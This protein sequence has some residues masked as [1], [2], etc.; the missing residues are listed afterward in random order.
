VSATLPTLFPYTT[1]FRSLALLQVYVLPR[2][3]EKL[4]GPQAGV[5]T[6]DV[7]FFETFALN[8]FEEGGL[9]L[10]CHVAGFF[11]FVLG[12][13]YLVDRVFAD[14]ALPHG[15]IQSHRQHPG[16]VRL[17]RAGEGG[18]PVFARLRFQQLKERID[19]PIVQL[20]EF[21]VSE[22]GQDMV[23]DM[24]LVLVQRIELDFSGLLAKEFP[25][26]VPDRHFLRLHP[27]ALEHVQL[28]RVEFLLDFLHAG[29]G[30]ADPLPLAIGA[31][32]KVQE[33]AK[34]PGL[35]LPNGARTLPGP[36][37]LLRLASWSWHHFSLL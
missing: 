4:R 5:Q 16:D 3:T 26:V 7:Q 18:T 27:H 30:D 6:Q 22:R 32:T 11:L 13:F 28:H 12:A 24:V 23:L 29:A 36:A 15:V 34:P 33:A 31:D 2:Q 21:E 8:G 35:V 1:L 20:R 25:E 37:L 14:Q 17:C 10:R 19:M 9:F